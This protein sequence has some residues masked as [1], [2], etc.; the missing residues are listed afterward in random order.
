MKSKEDEMINVAKRIL[1]NV[2]LMSFI[3]MDFQQVRSMTRIREIAHGIVES[4]VK[5][6]V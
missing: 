1:E 2:D 6:V 5:K 4:K 3:N